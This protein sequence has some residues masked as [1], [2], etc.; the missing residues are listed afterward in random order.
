MFDVD[1]YLH[2]GEVVYRHFTYTD[3]SVQNYW[4][5]TEFDKEETYSGKTKFAIVDK[6]EFQCNGFKLMNPIYERFLK[7]EGIR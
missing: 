5:D 1:V 7:E 6:F 4:V 3:C 2:S